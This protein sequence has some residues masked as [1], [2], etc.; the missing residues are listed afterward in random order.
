M[1]YLDRLLEVAESDIRV[2]RRKEQSYQ[3]SWM[4]R[5]GVG[6]FMMLAR[7]WDR[8]EA[9]VRV[10]LGSAPPW[11]IFAHIEERS[12]SDGLLDDVRDLRRYL[13]LV[14]AHL[15]TERKIFLEPE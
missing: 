2:L 6:A 7:K 11:D 9:Q 10:A 15:L 8:I 1:H 13:L 4:R 5:G 14:E 3:G 12:Q